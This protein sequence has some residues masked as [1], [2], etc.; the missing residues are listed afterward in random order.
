MADRLQQQYLDERRSD[1]RRRAK[2]RAG[3]VRKDDGKDAAKIRVPLGPGCSRAQHLARV[4][5]SPVSTHSSTRTADH[6]SRIMPGSGDLSQ[7]PGH[8]RYRIER[9]CF[10]ALISW[11]NAYAELEELSS[12]PPDRL[13]SCLIHLS[14]CNPEKAQLNK[15][16]LKLEAVLRPHH[17][18]F[19]GEVQRLVVE[20]IAT[21]Q[22][23][24]TDL[25]RQKNPSY[26]K[27]NSAQAMFTML[28]HV[29]DVIDKVS[30]TVL[31]GSLV[32]TLVSPKPLHHSERMAKSLSPPVC[33]ANPADDVVSS[34]EVMQHQKADTASS[35]RKGDCRMESPHCLLLNTDVRTYCCACIW[36]SIFSNPTSTRNV[37][38]QKAQ[39][40]RS[41]C[42]GC[43]GLSSR[44][45]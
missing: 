5:T 43:Q 24:V 39:G 23:L 17:S 35:Q 42:H 18:P 36:A 31:P 11:A 21:T 45:V 16:L 2:R 3:S 28:G 26:S 1:K 7:I 44:L 40:F 22:R 37:E 12:L 15:Q 9:Y 13:R 14:S 32:G 29:R 33:L 34:N 41:Y 6:E 20:N 19:A 8:Q 10:S 4:S 30:Q 27:T 38:Q 25:L